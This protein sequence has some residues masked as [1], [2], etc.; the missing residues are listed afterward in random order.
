MDI[1]SKKIKE[2]WSIYNK[3]RHNYF[4]L[5]LRYE[6]PRTAEEYFCTPK[7][8]KIFASLGVDGIHYCTVPKH[9]D[10]IFV[11][12]PEAG[13]DRYVFPVAKDI[14]EFFQL[15]SALHGT[16]LIDQIPMFG[17]DWLEAELASHIA[18]EDA[19]YRV[20]LSAFKDR[21]DISPLGMS[22]YDLVMKRYREFDPDSIKYT[23]LYYDTLGI[24]E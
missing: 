6:D 2:T 18:N 22:A 24:D 1:N 17:K 12:T 14:C 3:D 15:I 10:S 5:G 7:G 8:A 21:F 4:S 11:V 9:G 13:D 16:Q 19:A 20:E 23:S